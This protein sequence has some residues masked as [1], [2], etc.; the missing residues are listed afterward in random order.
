MYIVHQVISNGFIL[1]IPILLWNFF[2]DKKLPP[3]FDPKNFDKNIP[4]TI[5]FCEGAFRMIFFAMPFTMKIN[6]NS[7][8]GKIG[9]LV[10]ITGV[11]IYFLTW[12]PLILYPKA[13]W[14]NSLLGLAAPA[15]TPLIWLIGFSMIV[16]SYYFNIH[17]S[18]W[19]YI[20]PALLFVVSHTFHVIIAFKNS[21]VTRKNRY[22]I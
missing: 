12:V 5:T 19:Y 3:F 13:T 17:Y 15:Y 1:F 7:V 11:L 16:D 6:L 8:T 21:T 2:L 10:F 4:K 22:H 9:I 20:V 14:S 18:M